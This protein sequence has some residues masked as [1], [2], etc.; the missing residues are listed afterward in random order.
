MAQSKNAPKKNSGSIIALGVLLIIILLALLVLVF[1]SAGL[2]S[3]YSKSSMPQTIPSET[4]YNLNSDALPINTNVGNDQDSDGVPDMLD[5]CIYLFN[6]FQE[7]N[8]HN[9]IGDSCDLVYRNKKT[10]PSTNSFIACSSNSQ[11]GTSSTDR[12]CVNNDVVDRQTSPTCN[13]PG[14]SSSICNNQII[15]SIISACSSEEICSNGQCIPI[16]PSCTP[17]WVDTSSCSGSATC[18]SSSSGTKQQSDNCG[19]TRSTSCTIPQ[20]QCGSGYQCTSGQCIPVA[21]SCTSQCMNGA[22][23]CSGNGVQICRDYNGDGCYEWSNPSNCGFG[24]TCQGGYCTP[25]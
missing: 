3:F 5:N 4:V 20:I 8:N 18:S 6:P 17:N 7:D 25:L 21:P 10:H 15:D 1:Y 11:C 22:Q 12:I 23:Q 13:N 19:N 14:T 2:F 24:K 9:R 16:T